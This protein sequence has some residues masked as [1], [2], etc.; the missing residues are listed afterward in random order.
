MLDNL[1]TEFKARSEHEIGLK[2]FKVILKQN[3]SEIFTKV[4]Y[5]YSIFRCFKFNAFKNILFFNILFI[6]NKFC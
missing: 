3:C 6:V 4:N 1:K 5:T 2:D